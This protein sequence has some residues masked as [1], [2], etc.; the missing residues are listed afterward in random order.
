VGF[1]RGTPPAGYETVK[2]I[3]CVAILIA[4]PRVLQSERRLRFLAAGLM[5]AGVALMLQIMQKLGSNP[6]NFLGSFQQLKS[7]AAFTTWNP[8]TIG[9]ASMLLV[10]TA[11]LG[12]IALRQSRINSGLWFCFATA[13]SLIP[14][15]VFSRGASLS[16]AAGFVFFLCLVGR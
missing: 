9:Q 4:L 2:M 15:L 10:F 12:W 11:G 6:A 13:F 7:A 16:I 3:G 14:A 8:N 5:C 1:A